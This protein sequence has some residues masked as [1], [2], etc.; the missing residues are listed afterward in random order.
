M[1]LGASTLC[2]DPAILWAVSPQL[3]QRQFSKPFGE[4]FLK[5]CS[6]S[7]TRSPSSE[8]K[9]ILRYLEMSYVTVVRW[10]KRNVNLIILDLR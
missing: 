7:C 9:L 10:E 3:L 4:R 1:Y 6:N 5:W 8:S 2:S